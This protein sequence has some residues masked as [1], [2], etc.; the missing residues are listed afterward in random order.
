MDAIRNMIEATGLSCI[1]VEQ[2][3]DVV[4]DFA[5]EILIPGAGK[6][7]FS[8]RLPSSARQSFDPGSCDR[9]TESR[10]VLTHNALPYA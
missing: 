3:V 2:H 8:A 7:G 10:S 1:L 9:P 5:D 6:A 4:L